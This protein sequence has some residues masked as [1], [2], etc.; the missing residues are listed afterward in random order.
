MWLAQN[1][2][3]VAPPHTIFLCW[4]GRNEDERAVL[5]VGVAPLK[6]VIS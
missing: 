2:L 3:H 1:Q 4:Q 6:E 5:I